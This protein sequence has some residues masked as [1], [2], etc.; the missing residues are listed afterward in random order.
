MAR[1]PARRRPD[2]QPEHSVTGTEPGLCRARCDS[3]AAAATKA[4]IAARSPSVARAWP[5]RRMPGLGTGLLMRP[6]AA[7]LTILIS[8][9]DYHN[10][11]LR[12]KIRGI[13]LA[14]KDGT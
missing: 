14:A 3:V 11:V 12:C 4:S 13:N 10:H 8:M 7:R 5:L 9:S 1:G 6:A 2:G